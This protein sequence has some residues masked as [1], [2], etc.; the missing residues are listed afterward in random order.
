MSTLLEKP[1]THEQLEVTTTSR[2]GK[3]LPISLLIGC[4]LTIIVA[5]LNYVTKADEEQ[6][7]ILRVIQFKRRT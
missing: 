1:P 2:S 5:S 7:E 6:L 3:L 4:I